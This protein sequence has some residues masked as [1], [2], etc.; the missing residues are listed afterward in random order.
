MFL[1]LGV[2]LSKWVCIILIQNKIRVHTMVYPLAS[3]ISWL[4]IWN[5]KS[6][7]EHR[8]EGKKLKLAGED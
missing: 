2:T 7:F 6:Q 1:T 5:A 4:T 8:K 3:C